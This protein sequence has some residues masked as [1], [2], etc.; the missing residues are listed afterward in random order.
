MGAFGGKQFNAIGRTKG[1]WTTRLHAVVDA[2]GHPIRLKIAAG[3]M[4]DNLFAK[5]LLRGKKAK[6]VIA[7]KA[8]DTNDIRAYLMKRKERAVIPSLG[9]RTQPIKY[10]KRLYKKRSLVER[11]FQRIKSFR[12]IATRYE[13]SSKMFKSMIYIACALICIIF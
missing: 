12:R 7:D 9:S 1:G 10:S 4:N 5:I 3:Q 13:K 6:N 2:R 8:Y 11:F